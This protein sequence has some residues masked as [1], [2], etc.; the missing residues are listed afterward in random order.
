MKRFIKN[1]ILFFL[2]VFLF[3]SA[4][5]P[6]YLAAVNCGE[7]KDIEENIEIQRKNHD[8]LIGLGYN[9][10]TTYY[11]IVNANYYQAEVIALGTSRVM[12]F[13][14]EFFKRSFYNCGGAVSWNYD[15]YVNFLENLT[16]KPKVIIL[17]VDQWVFN[18][19]WNRNRKK[20][21]T[22]TSI[23]KIDRNKVSM[24]KQIIKDWSQN[25]W[26]F[27][28]LN[29]YKKNIGF[30][31]CIKDSGFMLDGSYFYGDIYR[32]PE[33]QSDYQFRNSFERMKKGDSP[34][35]W[36]QEI[37]IETIKQLTSLLKY[38]AKHNI[39][40]IGFLPP[41]APSVCQSMKDSGNYSYI[42]KIPSSCKE[43]FDAY[44][45]ELYNF[46]NNEG[47]TVIDDYFVD[48]FHG[49]DIVYGKILQKMIEHKSRI[50][51]Y[52]DMMKVNSLINKS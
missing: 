40:V 27:S 15:E 2:P 1:I 5:I 49:N 31:G 9:E 50:A 11:K 39:Y 36:G 21:S 3:C 42:D 48:G 6:F 12:Q 23:K 30:N 45:Y 47:L 44:G 38:C 7:F 22:F 18:N 10:Q 33:E 32:K 24:L 35:V 14:K 28:S 37:E 25:K 19:E 4:T 41:F 29:L 17:G 16:Y 13:K 8:V 51:P 43:I 26:S 34:F 20:Y 46:T 52:L